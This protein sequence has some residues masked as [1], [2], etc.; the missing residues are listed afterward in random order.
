MAPSFLALQAF[1]RPP[2]SRAASHGA[3]R[4]CPSS[5]GAQSRRQS[6][7]SGE[8]PIHDHSSGLVQSIALGSSSRPMSPWERAAECAYHQLLAS[9]PEGPA[10]AAA[11]E[12]DPQCRVSDCRHVSKDQTKGLF[13]V[14]GW[15][16]SSVGRTHQ[17]AADCLSRVTPVV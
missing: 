15:R 16:P 1:G 5:P 10:S 3:E 13:S 8:K 4:V 11:P 9:N 14:S 2:A 12:S 17:M 7:T 6:P